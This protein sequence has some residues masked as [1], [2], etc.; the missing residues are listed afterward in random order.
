MKEDLNY[1]IMRRLKSNF[2]TIYKSSVDS[3]LTTIPAN[4]VEGSHLPV[5]FSW[6]FETE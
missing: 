2:R 6:S 1:G 3:I 4:D 5:G